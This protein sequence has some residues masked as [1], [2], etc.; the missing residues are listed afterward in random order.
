MGCELMRYANDWVDA[1]RDAL[2]N[3]FS[4]WSGSLSVEEKLS[5]IEGV[6]DIVRSDTVLYPEWN[7]QYSVI[8]GCEGAAILDEISRLSD[9]ID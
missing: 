5:V 8:M 6:K 2:G 7:A 1:T 4:N 9:E 3:A